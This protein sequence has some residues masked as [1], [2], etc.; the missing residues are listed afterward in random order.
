MQRSSQHAAWKD[1]TTK[2]QS[3]RGVEKN[4]LHT[5]IKELDLNLTLKFKAIDTLKVSIM[6]THTT[7]KRKFIFP[8]PVEKCL[9]N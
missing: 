8:Q 4:R 9:D 1:A 5:D 6:R 7:N 3:L 2:T